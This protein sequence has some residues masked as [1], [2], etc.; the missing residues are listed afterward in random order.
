MMTWPAHSAGCWARSSI[1]RTYV[2]LATPRTDGIDV[3]VPIEDLK[4]N[5]VIVVSAGEQIPADGRILQG[6]GLVDER[7]IRGLHGISRKQ[8]DDEVFAGSTIQLGELHIEV[9]RHGSET[10]VAKLAQIML[11]AT[12]CA[13]WLANADP[14]RREV[15]RADRCANHGYCRAGAAHR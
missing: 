11:E 14:A 5:D 12:N 7:M 3:E 10:Q 15:R 13:T 1:S 2:R 4:P 6:R 9:L 8:P